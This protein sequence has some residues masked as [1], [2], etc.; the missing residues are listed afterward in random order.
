MFSFLRVPVILYA[1]VRMRWLAYHLHSRERLENWQ[2]RQ[3]KP[4]LRFIQRHSPYFRERLV[5]VTVEAW[6]RLPILSKRVE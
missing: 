3:L 5:D 4:H 6:R 1:Y 2:Q